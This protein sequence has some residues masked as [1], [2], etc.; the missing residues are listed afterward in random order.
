[1]ETNKI[2]IP[3]IVRGGINQTQGRDKLGSYSVDYNIEAQ[4]GWKPYRVSLEDLIRTKINNIPNMD[5]K[6]SD[7]LANSMLAIMKGESKYDPLARRI[8]LDKTV[9]TGLFQINSSNATYLKNKYNLDDYDVNDYNSQINYALA[10]Y[11]NGGRNR[12]NFYKNN[13][14]DYIKNMNN[15]SDLTEEESQLARDIIHQN[16]TKGNQLSRV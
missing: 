7:K 9:D 8:N 3:D 4:D 2:L 15:Q 5:K 13:Q 11:A 1:M 10:T 6:I 12:W 14:K 16:F